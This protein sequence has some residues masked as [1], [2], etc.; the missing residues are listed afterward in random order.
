LKNK[1]DIL[2]K[3][4]NC[5]LTSL[6]ILRTLNR[7]LAYRASFHYT[8]I[9]PKIWTLRSSGRRFSKNKNIF[10][11]ATSFH[12]KPQNISFRDFNLKYLTCPGTPSREQVRRNKLCYIFFPDTFQDKRMR[13]SFLLFL[14][15]SSFALYCEHPVHN[16]SPTRTTIK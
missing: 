2:T 14:L 12:L 6:W 8:Q 7:F 16:N 15:F 4:K 10:E 1:T 3:N 9:Y 11:G 13:S 5:R